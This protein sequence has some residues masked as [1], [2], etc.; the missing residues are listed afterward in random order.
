MDEAGGYLISGFGKDGNAD[1]QRCQQ[2]QLPW[3]YS[4]NGC[5]DYAYDIAIS[6][7]QIREGLETT[8][9]ITAGICLYAEANTC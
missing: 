1:L 6:A 8:V 2:T 5:R 3:R 9:Q 7:Y 4:G